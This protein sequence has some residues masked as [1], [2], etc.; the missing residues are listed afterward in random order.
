MKGNIKMDIY[1][2]MKEAVL[3]G[4]EEEAVRLAEQALEDYDNKLNL[5]DKLVKTEDAIAEIDSEIEKLASETKDSQTVERLAKIK[6][7]IDSLEG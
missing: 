5:I 4:D 6:F 2:L 7:I 3:D 1:E